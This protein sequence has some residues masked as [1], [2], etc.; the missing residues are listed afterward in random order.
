MSRPLIRSDVVEP[1]VS[2]RDLC[3]RVFADP[4]L[5]VETLAHG[6]QGRF[7]IEPHAHDDL[8]QLDLLVHCGGEAYADGRWHRLEGITALASPPGR[9]HGYILMPGGRSPYVYHVKV[10]CRRS[11]PAVRRRAFDPILTGIRGA[12][13]LIAALRIVVQLGY[14]RQSQPP[15]LI[16]RLAEALCRW[17]RSG[18][19][20]AG[21]HT[22]FGTVEELP[23]GIAAA[24]KLIDDRLDDPPALEELAAIAHLSPRHFTR[25]FEA[26]FGGTAHAYATA[27]R[28]AAARELL[29]GSEMKIH[30][31]AERLGFASAA[32]FSRWFA[33]QGGMSPR[34]YRQSPTVM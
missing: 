12:D 18:D 26:H 17:P 33:K 27:R 19:V 13:A 24:V 5:L 25:Q 23:A 22:A 6:V 10:R 9:K 31:V 8:L 20:A 7:T 4:S 11:W 1:A 15:A 34:A 16:P 21:G 32:I 14:I 2:R 29:L 30:Q 3:S 28:Y